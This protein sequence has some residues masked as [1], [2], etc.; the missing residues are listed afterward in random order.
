M[1]TRLARPEDLAALCALIEDYAQ[2]GVLLPRAADEVRMHLERFV[3]LTE[4]VETKLAL[5]ERLR[6]VALEPYGDR[7]ALARS[8]GRG[9]LGRET[10]RSG[11]TM[12]R[13]RKIARVRRDP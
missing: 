12:A 6:C 4:T 9:R 8:G 3:V 5:A 13:R 7:G 2:Q 11:A 10:T 1:K